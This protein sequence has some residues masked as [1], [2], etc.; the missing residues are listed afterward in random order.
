M[1]LTTS[2]F[3]QKNINNYK[4]VIVPKKF[5]FVKKD[6]QYQTSSLTKFLFNK[7]GFTVFLSDQKLPIDLSKN[8]CLALTSEVED[9]SSMFSTKITI[10]LKD[11]YNNVVFS[12]KEGTSK[13]KDYKKSYHEAIRDAFKSIKALNYNYVPLK[14]KP[15][16]LT[17]QSSVIVK[18]KV[19]T[20]KTIKEN[21]VNKTKEITLYAQSTANGYQLVNTTP[22]VVFQV[23]K[24]NVKDVFILKNKNG[25]LYKDDN[26]WFAEY[27]KEGIKVIEKYE[28]KF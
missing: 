9:E 11:C 7:D 22:E 2:I 10:K 1:I 5:D 25:I 17:E 12:S 20:A 21:T 27:Y 18:P 13:L 19:I 23:L 16:E 6:D 8:R 26:T 14:E 15:E 28:V 4:Y 3:A 24:T